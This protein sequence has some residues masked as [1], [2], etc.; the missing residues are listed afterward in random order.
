MIKI[1]QSHSLNYP[2]QLKTHLGNMFCRSDVSSSLQYPYFYPMRSAY[3][4][5]SALS[6]FSLFAVSCY[7]SQLNSLSAHQL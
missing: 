5:L 3:L 2:F 6:F 4:N 1:E 7:C